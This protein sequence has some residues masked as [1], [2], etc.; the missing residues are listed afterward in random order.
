[1]RNIT[2]DNRAIP[3]DKPWESKALALCQRYRN[4]NNRDLCND[5]K[6]HEFTWKE[7]LTCVPPKAS[8]NRFG[9]TNRT[10][11]MKIIT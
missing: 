3:V 10:T 4:V 2:D 6:L 1:M 8:L 7:S 9:H 5:R 11:V